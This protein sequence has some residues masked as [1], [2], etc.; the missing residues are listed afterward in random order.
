M[1]DD[2]P[3]PSDKPARQPADPEHV[4][5]TM[6][7]LAGQ[8]G[9]NREVKT[10]DVGVLDVECPY[11]HAAPGRPCTLQAKGTGEYKQLRS[12]T[13]HPSRVETWEKINKEEK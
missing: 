6:T 12:T 1:N 10:T 9:W 7:W 5:T 2:L 13:A 3:P 4:A 11:C 8:L